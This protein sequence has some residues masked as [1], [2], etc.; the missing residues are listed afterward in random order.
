[1]KTKLEWI[2]LLLQLDCKQ[3][4][5]DSGIR[6]ELNNPIIINIEDVNIDK[7][8]II[9]LVVIINEETEHVLTFM[10]TNILSLDKVLFNKIMTKLFKEDEEDINFGPYINDHIANCMFA[11]KVED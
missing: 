5:T 9:K 4:N 11:L 3:S 8:K 6:F 10:T 2:E 1:M 7:V